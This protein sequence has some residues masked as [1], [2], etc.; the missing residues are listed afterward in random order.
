V[1]LR[2]FGAEVTFEKS[3][4]LVMGPRVFHYFHLNLAQ[5]DL[6][7]VLLKLDLGLPFNS[8]TMNAL[9][10]AQINDFDLTDNFVPIN[11][12]LRTYNI[13]FKVLN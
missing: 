8:M 5:S 9:V 2:C 7:V 3:V 10:I 12:Y 4:G 11:P 1:Q 13:I 6:V